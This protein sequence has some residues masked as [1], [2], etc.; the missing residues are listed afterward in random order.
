MA[1][2]KKAERYRELATFRTNE[3]TVKVAAKG[4]TNSQDLYRA[5]EHLKIIADGHYAAEKGGRRP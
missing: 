5:A 3:C 2:K 1:N 4:R